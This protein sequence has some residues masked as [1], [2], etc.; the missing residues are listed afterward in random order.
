MRNGTGLAWL[1]SGTRVRSRLLQGEPVG[2]IEVRGEQGDDGEGTVGPGVAGEDAGEELCYGGD[3]VQRG[4][5]GAPL[6][7]LRALARPDQIEARSHAQPGAAGV[8]S[9]GQRFAGAITHALTE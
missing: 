6:C 8:E 7:W 3:F 1:T 9:T 4:H 2:V 5:S